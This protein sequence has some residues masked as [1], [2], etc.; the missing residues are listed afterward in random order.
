MRIAEAISNGE[1]ETGMRLNQ[2]LSLR[3][4]D[5]TWWRSHY[6]S[7]WNLIELFSNMIDVLDFIFLDSHNSIHKK[8]A[9]FL[10]RSLRS[11]DFASFLHLTL[12]ILE[13]TDELSKALQREDQDIINVM[14]LVNVSK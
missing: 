4:V 8:E 3:R 2:E 13:I 5:D 7:L 14:K 6:K 9:C 1:I 12:D 10:V 11:F